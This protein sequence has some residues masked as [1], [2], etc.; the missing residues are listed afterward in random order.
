MCFNISCVFKYSENRPKFNTGTQ[1][2]SIFTQIF[3]FFFTLIPILEWFQQFIIM[4][5]EMLQ[6]LK[7]RVRFRNGYEFH[8]K[9]SR[10]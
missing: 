9:M 7:S 3:L 1:C 8:V 6:A 4:Q 10:N 5:T 2:D